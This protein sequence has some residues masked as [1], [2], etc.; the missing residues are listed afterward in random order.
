MRVL[1]EHPALRFLLVLGACAAGNACRDS[2]PVEAPRSTTALSGNSGTAH[3]VGPDARAPAAGSWP[4]VKVLSRCVVQILKA[5][6]DE[7]ERVRA[8]ALTRLAALGGRVT[9]IELTPFGDHLQAVEVEGANRPRSA[10][11]NASDAAVLARAALAPIADLL[12]L[13]AAE[14]RSLAFVSDHSIDTSTPDDWEAAADISRTPS[15]AM[16]PVRIGEDA[17]YVQLDKYG[18]A[19]S[20]AVTADRLP[21][22]TTCD[23]VMPRHAVELA[24]IGNMLDWVSGNGPQQ[25][26]PVERADILDIRH[27]PIIVRGTALEGNA[28]VGTVYV[29]DVKRH[30]LPFRLF[31]DPSTRQVVEVQKRFED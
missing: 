27:E 13:S 2:A 21:P 6:L 26:G 5:P 15:T 28:V 9:S 14:M 11:R 31:V 3:A 4:H 7:Q 23:E 25:E 12:G 24:V 19:V 8:A 20:F 17:V 22:V 10:P 29:V 30:K 1:Q 16:M 18:A